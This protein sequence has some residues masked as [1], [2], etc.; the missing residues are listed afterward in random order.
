MRL[1]R[2][3]QLTAALRSAT[4]RRLVEIGVWNGKRAQELGSAALRRSRAVDYH[5]FDLFELLSEEEL[6]AELSKRPPSQAEVEAELA[7]F[8][9]K[10]A[11]R[12]LLMPWYGRRFAFELHR[13]YT[14]KTLPAFRRERPEFRADFVFIDGGHSIATIANDWEHCHQ[15]TAPDGEIYLDDYYDNEELAREFGCNRLVDGLAQDPS[16]DVAVL[17]VKDTAPKIG[18][19]QIARVRRA[20]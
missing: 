2:Y 6:E 14:H 12:G 4:R 7:G 15:L 5:G 8:A 16:W 13:G 1:Q 10:A 11:L 18:T 3:E 9:R 17:P 19:I 20:T